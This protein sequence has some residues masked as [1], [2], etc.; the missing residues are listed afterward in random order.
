MTR[1]TRADDSTRHSR[2]YRSGL[3][4]EQAAA[5]RTRILEATVRLMADEPTAVSIPAVADEA[6]VSVPTVY[7]HFGDKA[8]LMEAMVPHV[9]ERL[10]FQPARIPAD[11]DDL[12]AL[13]R[14]LFHH[15]QSADPLVRAALAAG[16]NPARR[17]SVELRMS[18]LDEVLA[19]LDPGLDAAHRDRVARVAVILTCSQALRLWEERFDIG[20]DEVADHVSWAI[21]TLVEGSRK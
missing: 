20:V 5:T 14:E 18:M 19:T 12:D 11:L 8:G 3:R 13:V 9:G 15:Y 17:S 7:R 6:G 1:I 21:R 16:G 2:P 4:T 10:G